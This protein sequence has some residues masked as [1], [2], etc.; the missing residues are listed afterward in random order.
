MRADIIILTYSKTKE[1]I[2]VTKQCIKSLREAKN[3]IGINIYVV[4]SY[5]SEIK[6]DGAN[7]IFFKENDFNYNRSMNKGFEHT[8]N[9]YV[10]FANNDLIFYD[11]WL[12][13]CYH[14]FNMDFDSVSPY[15]EVTHPRFAPKGDYLLRGYQVGF[16]IAGWCIGVKR[17][18]FEK[19]GG[20]NTAVSFW[21]SDNIYG[22]QLRLNGIKHALV[23]NSLVKHLD[24]GSQTLNS[25]PNKEKTKLTSS[26]KKLFNN[27]VKKMW[28]NA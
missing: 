24:F 26:Q 10:F 8:T 7:M 21:Y 9:D 23:C 22:E 28:K 6:Y 1:H 17:E 5:D 2:N 3:K 15:C 25:L 16:H 14:V 27:E 13:N 12:D 19:I 18:M 11:W 4:E 20:F